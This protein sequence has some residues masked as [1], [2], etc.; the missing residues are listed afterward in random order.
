[1][2]HLGRRI[3][4]GG[5]KGGGE[6]KGRAEVVLLGD[7]SVQKETFIFSFLDFFP[8]KPEQHKTVKNNRE[9]QKCSHKRTIILI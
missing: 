3:G 9:I 8:L 6:G 4:G 2:Y 1:M 7:R 5:R